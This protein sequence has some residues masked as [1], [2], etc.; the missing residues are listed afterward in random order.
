VLR[1]TYNETLGA[2]DYSGALTLTGP[3]GAL[4]GAVA[5]EPPATL[6]LTPA[7]ALALDA[8]YKLR[9]QGA[10]DL[11]GNVQTVAFTSTFKTL[12]TQPPTMSLN[13]PPPGGWTTQPRPLVQVLVSDALSGVDTTTATLHLDGRL[14]TASASTAAISFTPAAALAEGQHAVEAGVKDRAGNPS[15]LTA[16][17][18]VD[19]LAPS[20][21]ALAGVS[22]GQTVAG[23]LSLSATAAEDGSGL[24]RVDFFRNGAQFASATAAQSLTTPWN[25]ASVADGEYLLSAHAADVAGNVGPLGPALRVVVNNHV[26]TVA[27][28]SPASGSLVRDSVMVAASV[29]EPVQRVDFQAGAGTLVSDLV[30]PYQAVLDVSAVPEGNVTLTATAYG[31]AAGET[32]T[33]GRTIVVDR[34]APAAPDVTRIHAESDGVSALVLGQ[35]GAAEAGARVDAQNLVTGA[36]GF[37]AAAAADGSFALRVDGVLDQTLSLTATDAAGN[38]SA[39]ATLVISEQVTQDGVPLTGLKLWVQADKDLTLDVSG[40]VSQWLDQSGNGNHLFQGTASARPLVVAEAA[41]GHP[42]LRFDGS[43]DFLQFTTRFNQTLRTV[44]AVVKD[45]ATGEH[46]LL[47][48]ATSATADFWPGTTAWWSSSA[49]QLVRD[50]QT[51]VNSV[52]VNGLVDPRP[53]TLSVVSL[54]INAPAGAAVTG[55][56]ADRLFRHGYHNRPWPGDA[57]ELLIYDRPL[58]ANDQKAVEDYL[59]RKYA[60]YAPQVGTPSINPDGGSFSGSTTVTLGSRTAGA[61]I[62]YT[63]DG[64]EPGAGSTPYTAPFTLSTSTT[65][66]ARAFRAGFPDSATATASFVRSEEFSPLTYG[67]DLLLWVRSDAGLTADAG[68]RV[69]VWKDQSGRANDLT[70]WASSLQPRVSG[71]RCSWCCVRPR[72]RQAS[73]SCWATRLRAR[74]TSG[75]EPRRCGAVARPTWALLWARPSSTARPSTAWPTGAIR[76]ASVLRTWRC[77]RW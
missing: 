13:A 17:F 73:A 70:Q 68:G 18:G 43:D 47:G 69:S 63:L 2:A 8:A 52:G 1:V 48:D 5:L 66:K 36:Q 61:L 57:A 72:R 29:N 31:V 55:V 32:A 56:S 9:A 67:A 11:S 45:T 14:V 6:A 37:S 62:T 77:C 30:A 38:R 39:A 74:P 25:T 75:P 35:A 54:V 49:N 23:T 65:V 12:D 24:A 28:T 42:V 71:A 3:A 59:A 4:A 51:I 19:T 44:V 60:L 27:I 76:R 46:F 21:A 53:Q 58:S 50:G 16:A 33:A 64:S 41:G 26:L 10:V 22:D 15:A 40:R 7:A 34:T 20:A